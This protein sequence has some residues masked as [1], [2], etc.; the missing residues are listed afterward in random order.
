MNKYVQESEGWRGGAKGVNRSV[1]IK[2]YTAEEIKK[3]TSRLYEILKRNRAISKTQLLKESGV[4]KSVWKIAVEWLTREYYDVA[5]D[6]DGTLFVIDEYA[7][8]VRQKLLELN[9]WMK[10]IKKELVVL[11]NEIERLKRGVRD[12]EQKC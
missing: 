2:K 5:E 7:W 8:V 1:K 3:I 4:E 9:S 6:D 12:G 10:E 11:K